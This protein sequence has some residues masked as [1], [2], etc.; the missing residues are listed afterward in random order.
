MSEEKDAVRMVVQNARSFERELLIAKLKAEMF[1]TS[2]PTTAA[3]KAWREGWNQRAKSLIEQLGGE[4][5]EVT[6]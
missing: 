2:S 6:S 5:D 4:V 3:D 1:E